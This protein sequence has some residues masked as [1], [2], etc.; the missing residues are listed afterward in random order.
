MAMRNYAL[1]VVVTGQI[2]Q[3]GFGE[4]ESIQRLV[5][6]GLAIIESP[7]PISPD[8]YVQAGVVV[9]KPP[10]PSGNHVFDY[11][12]KAWV[13]PRTLDRI[14]SDQWAV[15]KSHR[16]RAE[17]GGFLW[18]GGTFD[19]D[20]VSQSKI[21]GA[22]L[23]ALLAAQS[24]QPFSVDWTLADGTVRTLSGA[25]MIAVGMALGAHV[26]AV[27]QKGRVKK[28]TIMNATTEAEV[29]AVTW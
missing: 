28:Q 16:N 21:Q 3:A 19:S 5:A 15:V 9:S 8:D 25:D 12:V 24:A 14:K 4:E 26:D 18:G 2:L 7:D 1:Y 23:M 13:D 11:S 29:A 27:H 10:P 17:V 22:A 6:P 20:A